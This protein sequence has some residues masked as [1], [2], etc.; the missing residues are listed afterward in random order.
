[1]FINRIVKII[2]VL[3]GVVTIAT[4][5]GLS[6]TK[7]INAA[8]EV[9][10]DKKSATASSAS[11]GGAYAVYAGPDG[12]TASKSDINGTGVSHADS[13]GASASVTH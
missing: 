7:S 10:V 13:K 3:A 8:E 12:G 6:L 5:F 1:M 11:V 9:V 2:T 4:F